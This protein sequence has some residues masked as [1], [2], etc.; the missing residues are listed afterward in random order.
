VRSAATEHDSDIVGGA[1]DLGYFIKRVTFKL[2]ETY[3][4]PT[5]SGSQHFRLSG[6]LP[7]SYIRST[8][9]DKP[10]FEVTETG[11][12]VIH[13]IHLLGDLFSR[14]GEFEIQI[15]ITFIQESGEKAV[16]LYHH[17]KLHPWTLSG[18]P[19]I[20]P[21]DV[22]IKHGPVHSWQYDEI[23]FNDP[24]QSF[25]SILATAPPTPLPKTKR[26]P[27]PFHTANAT[28]EALTASHGG[29]PEFTTQMEKE[30]HERLENARKIVV[31]EQERLRGILLDKEK[32]L[33]ELQKLLSSS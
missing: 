4:N 20:P 19:E 8:D 7:S 22:A 18:E 16:T 15:R 2:H 13:S 26:R 3:P 25:L 11:C 33:E 31:A 24:F 14:W 9:I 17:L 29:V 5:R 10:P 6:R 27:I 12:A 21:L 32:E 28:A 23:V 1:D 30:E